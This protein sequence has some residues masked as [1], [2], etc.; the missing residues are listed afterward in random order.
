M[1]YIFVLLPSQLPTLT[2]GVFLPFLPNPVPEILLDPALLTGSTGV[3]DTGPR[4][5]FTQL[6][7][8]SVE[9]CDIDLRREMLNQ[10]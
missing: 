7:L 6:I 5:P 8:D 9:K 2:F 1:T 10:V 4:I 3:T